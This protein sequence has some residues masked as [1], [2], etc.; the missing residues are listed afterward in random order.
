VGGTFPIQ[1]LSVSNTAAGDGFSEKLDASFS[2]PLGN[3]LA[4]GSFSLLAAERRTAP[5]WA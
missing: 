4:S 5:A 1:S 3:V 2:N